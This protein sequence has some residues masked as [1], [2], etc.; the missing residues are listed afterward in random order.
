MSSR[1]L[2]LELVVFFAGAEQRGGLLEREDVLG[3]DEQLDE[4]VGQKAEGFFFGKLFCFRFL[5][6]FL[7]YLAAVNRI[8]N[9]S[10]SSSFILSPMT[11]R[12]FQ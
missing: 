11:S 1:Y 3:A 5:N 7:R 4:P 2:R 10:F 12:D 8:Y 6:L 9:L